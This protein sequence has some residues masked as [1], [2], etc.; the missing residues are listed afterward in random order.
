MELDEKVIKPTFQLPDINSLEDLEEL[1]GVIDE[2]DE[3]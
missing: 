3:E 1:S 2:E